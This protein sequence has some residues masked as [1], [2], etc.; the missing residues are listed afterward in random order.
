MKNFSKNPVR[1]L[2]GALILVSV[3]LGI[4]GCHEKSAEG[5][6]VQGFYYTCSM[7]SQVHEDKPGNCPICGMKLIKVKAAVQATLPTDSSLLYLVKPVTGTVVGDLKWVYPVRID[8]VDT[9]FADGEISYDSRQLNTVSSRVGGRIEKLYV[10]Y[11]NQA[12][13]AGQPLMELY[14][15][16]LLSV[17][18]F[19]LQA[20]RNQDTTIMNSL[21]ANLL[22]LG[23]YQNE[24]AQ[25]LRTRRPITSI[26]IKSPYAGI[27]Q[28]PGI[29]GAATPSSMNSM[30]A[31]NGNNTR[32]TSA[33]Q[34]LDIREGMYIRSGET[35]FSIQDINRI[36]GILNVLN[37]DLPFIQTG[38]T[39]QFHTLSNPGVA[40]Y[41][42][43]DFI[44]PYRE[45]GEKTSRLRIYLKNAVSDWKIGTLLQGKIIIHHKKSGWYVPRSA[46]NFLGNDKV[47]WVANKNHPD[48]YQAIRV[49]TGEEVGGMVGIESK[50]NQFDR[51]VENA[52]YM[53][54]SESPIQTPN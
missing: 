51:V 1:N 16:E 36:W 23:M 9:L 30:N 53:V 12:I 29:Q 25:V 37:G 54:D 7:H 50:I 8:P 15:P 5:K 39:V 27:S 40:Y 42:R 22:N 32:N 20:S 47:I 11:T 33:T 38:D 26:T 49:V 46:V 18:R 3:I 6:T 19:L 13:F 21:K 48:F 41:G 28:I 2:F 4:Q 34:P 43:I 10:R 44:P 14:S 31:S 17:Q 24:V 35:L 45:N 52:A